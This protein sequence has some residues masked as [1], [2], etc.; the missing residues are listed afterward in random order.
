[1]LMPGARMTSFPRPRASSPNTLPNLRARLGFHVVQRHVLLGSQLT[2]NPLYHQLVS[3]C[4]FQIPDELR[5]VHP[6]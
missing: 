4:H 1:M 6:T 5:L 2:K 3:N